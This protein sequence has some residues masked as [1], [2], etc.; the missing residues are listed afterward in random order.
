[1]WRK[2]TYLKLN[3]IPIC[4]IHQLQLEFIHMKLAISKI[5]S[6]FTATSNNRLIEMT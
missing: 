4:L 1:M 6:Q 3:K 2:L 5:I